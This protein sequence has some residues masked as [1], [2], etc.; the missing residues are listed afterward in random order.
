MDTSKELKSFRLTQIT[1]LGQKRGTGRGA[2]IDSV[3]ESVDAFYGS[4]I[5]SLRSWTA[6]APKLRDEP[7]AEGVRPSA[8]ASAALSSQDQPEPAAQ[9]GDPDVTHQ[10]G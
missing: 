9:A 6:P 10:A 2:F 8:L 3:L 1:P 4:V 5:Q 7:E